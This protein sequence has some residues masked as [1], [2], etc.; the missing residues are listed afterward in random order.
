MPRPSLSAKGETP[1][2]KFRLPPETLAQLDHLADALAVGN[3]SEA[4]RSVV[5]DAAKAYGWAAVKTFPKKSPGKRT[6]RG[7]KT[8]IV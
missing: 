3:R 6:K 8:S 7:H 4:L 5:A 1:H 2:S